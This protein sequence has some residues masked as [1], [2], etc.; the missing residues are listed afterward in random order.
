MPDRADGRDRGAVELVPSRWG[1][2]AFKALMGAIRVQ[3]RIWVTFDL[4]AG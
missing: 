3:D 1:I 2:A 4:P